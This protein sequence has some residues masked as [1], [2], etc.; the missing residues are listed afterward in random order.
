MREEEEIREERKGKGL[1]EE[2]KEGMKDEHKEEGRKKAK[3]H[4]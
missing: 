1:M 4:E 3:G 2:G